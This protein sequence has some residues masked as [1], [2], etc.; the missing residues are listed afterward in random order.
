MRRQSSR[1]T[2]S[3]APRAYETHPPTSDTSAHSPA[4]GVAIPPI[5]WRV[6]LGVAWLMAVLLAYYAVH[7]PITPAD[8]AQ[9]TAPPLNTSWTPA[10]VVARIVFAAIPDLVA[11]LWL[12]LVAGALGQTLWRVL[13]LP[14][15]GRAESRLI[16]TVLGLGVL[17]LAAFA[18]GLL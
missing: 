1:Q 14:M 15:S 4:A 9:L 3:S 10:R 8:L 18:L 17:G 5:A 16:G 13:R 2:P 7:K 6:A 12:A 11:P